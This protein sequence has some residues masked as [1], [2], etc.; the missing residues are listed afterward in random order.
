MANQ[1]QHQ[2]PQRPGTDREWDQQ[3][4]PSPGQ[5]IPGQGDQKPGDQGQKQNPGD[6]SQKQNPADQDTHGK[7]AIRSRVIRA[8]SRSRATPR[9]ESGNDSSRGRTKRRSEGWSAA[10]LATAAAGH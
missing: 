7:K 5:T 4:T 3:P 2:N 8:G 1:Q 9:R 6:Q 10:R